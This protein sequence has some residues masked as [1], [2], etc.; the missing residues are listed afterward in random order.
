MA[1]TFTNPDSG[2][3]TFPIIYPNAAALPT[4]GSYAGSLAVTLD[5]YTLYILDAVN[6]WIQ[7]GGG[8]GPTTAILRDGSQPPTSNIPWGGYGITSL[9]GLQGVQGSTSVAGGNLSASSGAGTPPGNL[10]LFTPQ[11]LDPVVGDSGNPPGTAKLRSIGYN[12]VDTRIEVLGNYGDGFNAGQINFYGDNTLALQIAGG[13]DIEAFGNLSFQAGADFH[14]YMRTH[15]PITRVTPAGIM[16]VTTGGNQDVT[17]ITGGTV[18][19]F[20]GATAIP[21]PGVV[22][23]FNS[24][25]T[26]S[27][28][29]SVSATT[30][31]SVVR[32]MQVFNSSGTSLGY[33][34]IYSSI[35]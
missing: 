35:T 28:D 1:V 12:G 24:N 32:K 25:S 20:I 9:L 14:G 22:A 8:S 10:D 31:G 3:A 18:A 26:I 19:D 2:V 29:N 5:T 34:A 11:S 17:A 30:P 21:A 16:A 33:I 13:T 15:F 23:K 6:G 27:V 7:A 4:E